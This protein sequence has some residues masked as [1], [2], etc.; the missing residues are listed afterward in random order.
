MQRI[1]SQAVRA[2]MYFQVTLK[3]NMML[4]P[5]NF[6]PKMREVLRANLKKE[7][8]GT[9]NGRY[10]YIVLVTKIHEGEGFQVPCLLSITLQAMRLRPAGPCAESR[11]ISMDQPAFQNS[12]TDSVHWHWHANPTTLAQ[13]RALPHLHGALRRRLGLRTVVP[14]LWECSWSTADRLQCDSGCMLHEHRH[15]DSF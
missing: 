14:T 12:P 2:A 5:R 15:P 11:A 8:E 7:V 4:H 13:L 1:G 10:G 9:C 6:G 3:R